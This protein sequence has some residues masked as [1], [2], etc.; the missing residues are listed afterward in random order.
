MPLRESF[1]SSLV[2]GVLVLGLP[3]LMVL[4]KWIAG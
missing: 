3:A 2:V 4:T 1:A